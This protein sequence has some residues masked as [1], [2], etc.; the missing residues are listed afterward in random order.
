M[1]LSAREEEILQSLEKAL[2]DQYPVLERRLKHFANL[3]G[4]GW[5]VGIGFLYLLPGLG[6]LFLGLFSSS[7]WLG[8]VAFLVLNGGAY[9]AS[10]RVN[11]VSLLRPNRAQSAPST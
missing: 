8:I 2:S 7:T 6:L 11:P 9:L 1:S 4:G 10:V 5:M 3:S